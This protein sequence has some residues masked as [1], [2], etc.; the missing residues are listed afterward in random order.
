MAEKESRIV[1]GK[2]SLPY[3][4]ALG[5]V[6]TRFFE[7]FKNKKIMGTKCPKCNRVLVPA[8]RFCPRCFEDT[9]EWVQVSAKGTVRTWSLITFEFS[10]QPMAPPYLIG[11]IHLD[12]ADTALSHFIGG[13]DLS[14][15]EKGRNEIKIGMK[16]EAKWR[17]E[18]QGNINDIEY[19]KPI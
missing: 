5:P 10:G 8:R 15:L 17:D 18:R 4:W 12:G 1:E 3:K 13:V 2:I 11:L 9:T 19:F 16:V 7:E 6:F 14:D